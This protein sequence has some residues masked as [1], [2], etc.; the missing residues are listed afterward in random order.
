MPGAG[1]TAT[2]VNAVSKF[3][4]AGYMRVRAVETAGAMLTLQHKVAEKCA[5]W[6][7]EKKSFS[8]K[9]LEQ[10][11]APLCR[12]SLYRLFE[13]YQKAAQ[14]V[15]LL[16]VIRRSLSITYR[17]LRIRRWEIYGN[18]VAESFDGELSDFLSNVIS[19]A[20]KGAHMEFLLWGL[21]YTIDILTS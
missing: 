5:E 12:A 18:H 1:K 3:A 6:A 14:E 13:L 2:V 8:R 20:I 19:K 15:P 16:Y 21:V 4:G 11:L 10:E 7:E 9:S 17:P